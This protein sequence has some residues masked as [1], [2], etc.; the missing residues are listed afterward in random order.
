MIQVIF[1]QWTIIRKYVKIICI[2][3]IPVYIFNNLD[4]VIGMFLLPMVCVI[5]LLGQ[6]LSFTEQLFQGQTLTKLKWNEP[7]PSDGGELFYSYI[8]N[9]LV[10]TLCSSFLILSAICHYAAT[11][12]NKSR[13]NLSVSSQTQLPQPDQQQSRSEEATWCFWELPS[14][15]L[16]ELCILIV[17]LVI[18]FISLSLALSFSSSLPLSHSSP[19]TITSL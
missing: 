9:S 14:C 11:S 15:P 12:T 4:F 7:L 5:R 6:L 16:S 2:W 3:S 13:S 8:F 10:F 18:L 17:F 1:I 19:L